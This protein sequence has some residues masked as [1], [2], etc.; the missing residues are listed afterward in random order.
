MADQL[1]N[2]L[3]KG[4]LGPAFRTGS[5]HHRRRE[6]VRGDVVCVRNG[7]F[8]RYG[9]WTGEA[10][11]TYDKIFK[12]PQKVHKR[13][14]KDF[15]HGSKSYSI[16]M[17]PKTYG[18]MIKC[19]QTSPISGVIMPPQKIWRLFERAEKVRRYKR[20]T[21][22]E[23]ADRAEQSLGKT[24]YASSEH[25]AVWCKTGI[26]ESQELEALQDLWD[27]VILY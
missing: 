27:K 13:S 11:I 22:E 21:P 18:R 9:I 17:F 2:T 15:L 10:V 14:L 24:G 23:T 26:S 25:F 16:C 8:N 12:G 4:L 20:Y 1:L 5:S 3:L 6:L 7:L 19:Q